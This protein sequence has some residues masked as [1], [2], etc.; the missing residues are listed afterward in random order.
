MLPGDVLKPGEDDVQ[1]LKQRLNL[2]LAPVKTESDS[3]GEDWEIGELLTE[4][5]RPNF[6][7][8]PHL[9][10]CEAYL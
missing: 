2:R 7:E 6:G 5:F 9:Q 4:W 3:N 10:L 8:L 1:G